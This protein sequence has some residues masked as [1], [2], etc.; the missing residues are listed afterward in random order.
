MA[1]SVTP[2]RT[3]G[4]LYLIFAV[5][6]IIS[7]FAFPAVMVPGDA[8]G[9]A[10][11]LA[12]AE[13]TY[14]IAIA[15]GLVT[16]ILFIAVVANLYKLFEHVD[17][18]QALAMVLFVTV[19]VALALANLHNRL[20]PLVLLGGADYLSVFSK[21]QLEALALGHLSLQRLGT[22]IV[23]LFWGLWLFPF[24]ALVIRSRFFPRILGV[25]LMI[26]GVGYFMSSATAIVLPGLRQTINQ[27]MTPLYFGELPIIV[28]LIR[29]AKVPPPISPR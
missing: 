4:V 13:Q 6:A 20:A 16:H 3:A 10:R 26:A 1:T 12:A 28:W 5:S 19:G 17:K 24:G 11:N 29:G 18:A 15:A 8:A 23:T 2:G 21:P 27:F 14:R 25:L 7:E 22:P 9:T